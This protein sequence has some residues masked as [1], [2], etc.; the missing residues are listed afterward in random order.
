MRKCRRRLAR[1]ARCC[2]A[3]P[4]PTN[5]QLSVRAFDLPLPPATKP[6]EHRAHLPAGRRRVRRRAVAGGLAAHQPSA[7]TQA[8]SIRSPASYCGVVGP[9]TDVTASCRNAAS[10]RMSPSIDHVGPISATVAEAALTLD[11]IAGHDDRI[12]PVRQ[13]SGLLRPRLSVAT[14]RAC[15]S[16]MRGHGLPMTLQIDPAVLASNG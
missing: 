16:A 8:G 15:A 10:F 6:V 3:S 9:Q 2:L 14:L 4:R 13:V 1:P 12:P 11:V 5:G 7:P